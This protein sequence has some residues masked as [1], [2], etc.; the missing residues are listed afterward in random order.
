M[1]PRYGEEEFRWLQASRQASG[2]QLRRRVGHAAVA[3]AVGVPARPPPAVPGLLGELV[4]AGQAILVYRCEMLDLI[5]GL[6]EPA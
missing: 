5:R 6:P 1:A 2:L 4:V 3:A